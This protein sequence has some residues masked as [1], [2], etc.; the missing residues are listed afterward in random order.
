MLYNKPVV[1][2][3][4]VPKNV[5]REI[6][7]VCLELGIECRRIAERRFL[8]TIG[9]HARLEGY[10]AVGESYDGGALVESMLVMVG[11][12]NALMDRFLE[13]LGQLEEKYVGVKAVATQHNLSWTA[14]SLYEELIRERAALEKPDR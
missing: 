3:Y 1:L 7:A 4:S 10:K 13:K 12:G 14:I 6:A 8:Q 5:H 9:C 2:L 11:F